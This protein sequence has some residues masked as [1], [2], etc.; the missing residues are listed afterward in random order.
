M[1]VE[2]SS[3]PDPLAEQALAAWENIL[4]RA[5]PVQADKLRVAAAVRPVSEQLAR[6]LSCKV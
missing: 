4:D 3:L 2:T 6:A 1:S 5:D